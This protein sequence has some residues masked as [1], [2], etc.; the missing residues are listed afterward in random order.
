[1]EIDEKD[2]LSSTVHIGYYDNE[3]LVGVARITDLDTNVIHI[4]RVAIAKQHRGL[5]LGAKLISA[6]ES[7]ITLIASKSTVPAPFT[8]ELSSQLHVEKFYEKLGYTRANDTVYLEA[9]IQHIDMKKTI[10]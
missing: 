9:G 1:M 6:C 3:K 8:I 7:V 2:Y 5:G 4:K 10:S